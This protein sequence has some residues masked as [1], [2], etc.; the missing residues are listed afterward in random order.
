[1]EITF[2]WKNS[3]TGNNHLMRTEF[4]HEHD[5][6]ISALDRCGWA[7]RTTLRTVDKKGYTIRNWWE[8]SYGLNVMSYYK[9][10]E[11]DRLHYIKN[12]WKGK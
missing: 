4:Q 6:W 8:A 9:N 7:D 12:F 10:K 2:E 3:E 1:M 5:A 11:E